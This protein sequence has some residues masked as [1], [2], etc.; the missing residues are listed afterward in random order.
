MTV[1]RVTGCLFGSLCSELSFVRF[2]LGLLGALS[3]EA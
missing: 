1:L 2:A 3:V